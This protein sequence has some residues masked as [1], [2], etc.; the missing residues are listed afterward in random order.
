[1]AQDGV[2]GKPRLGTPFLS[3]EDPRRELRDI[4]IFNETMDYLEEVAEYLD[5][6]NMA[7]Q[8]PASALATLPRAPERPEIFWWVDKIDRWGL[9]YPGTWFDQPK[10]FLDDIESVMLAKDQFQNQ[11][12]QAAQKKLQTTMDSGSNTR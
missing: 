2:R 12:S 5:Y 1:M 9:P 4:Q 6:A 8:L 11:R 10:D 3:E 7:D